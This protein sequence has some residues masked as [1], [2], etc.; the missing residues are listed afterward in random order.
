MIA[1]FTDTGMTQMTQMTQIEQMGATLT[2]YHLISLQMAR[3]CGR[4]VAAGSPTPDTTSRTWVR[5]SIGVAEAGEHLR[6]T[7][8]DPGRFFRLSVVV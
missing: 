8:V 7:L 1:L 2:A 5:V 3:S 6:R 4:G